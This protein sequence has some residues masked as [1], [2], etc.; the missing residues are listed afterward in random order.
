[1]TQFIFNTQS[2][3]S[4][5]VVAEDWSGSKGNKEGWTGGHRTLRSQFMAVKSCVLTQHFPFKRRFLRVQKNMF[6]QRKANFQNH[7]F[8]KCASPQ[9]GKPCFWVLA[10]YLIP[11]QWQSFKKNFFFQLCQ[12]PWALLAMV[13]YTKERDGDKG[14]LMQLKCAAICVECESA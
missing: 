4:R 7:S 3:E 5:L 14:L 2:S 8:G 10:V 11:K 12:Q 9:T 13:T 6:Q 1:M